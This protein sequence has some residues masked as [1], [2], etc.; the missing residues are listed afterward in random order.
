MKI[1]PLTL[2]SIKHTQQL[3]RSQ[4]VRFFNDVKSWAKQVNARIADMKYGRS[5]LPARVTKIYEALAD[6]EHHLDYLEQYGFKDN[7]IRRD[8]SLIRERLEV[9]KSET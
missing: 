1:R 3:K 2:P 8:L 6:I 7:S 5:Y 4:A 9:F